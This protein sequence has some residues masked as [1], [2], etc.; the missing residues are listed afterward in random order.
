[1]SSSTWAPAAGT[2]S[3]GRGH[4][5]EVRT[6]M[7]SV[8]EVGT[9]D[10]W[11]WPVYKSHHGEDP[12]V[13]GHVRMSYKGQ[14]GV[15]IFHLPPGVVTVK[16]QEGVYATR[17]SVTASTS[18]GHE[19]FKGELALAYDLACDPLSRRISEV[20]A[21]S[22]LLI[23]CVTA[24]RSVLVLV[25]VGMSESWPGRSQECSQCS[26]RYIKGAVQGVVRE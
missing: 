7:E 15:A 22:C 3:L 11:P 21:S 9:Y 20:E 8:A 26:G 23:Q 18:N 12:D 13:N 1:M 17:G 4:H 24:C 5:I 6:S 10:W 2:F 16:P 19:L 14:Q 25:L